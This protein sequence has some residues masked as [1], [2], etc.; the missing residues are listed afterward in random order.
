MILELSAERGGGGQGPTDKKVL[1]FIYVF[2]SNLVYGVLQENYF[3]KVTGGG[4]MH[5]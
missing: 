1:T 2:K 4:V 5:L 3:S